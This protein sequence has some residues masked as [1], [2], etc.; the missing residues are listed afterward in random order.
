LNSS[1]TLREDK[2]KKIS[3]KTKYLRKSM[4]SADYLKQDYFGKSLPA[5]IFTTKTTILKKSQAMTTMTKIKT[6]MIK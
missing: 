3:T 1:K 6:K 2:A 5:T 4:S